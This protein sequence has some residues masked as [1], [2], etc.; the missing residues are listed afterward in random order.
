MGPVVNGVKL[1]LIDSAYTE[2]VTILF[3]CYSQCKSCVTSER[4]F[5]CVCHQHRRY[6]SAAAVGAC[7][8]HVFVVTPS[9]PSGFPLPTSAFHNN[10]LSYQA[11]SHKKGS[12]ASETYVQIT[13]NLD[14]YGSWVWIGK[15]D[16]R[17]SDPKTPRCSHSFFSFLYLGP[18]ETWHAWS[19]CYRKSRALP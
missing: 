15:A 10:Y 2:R 19:T 16:W 8:K 14:S 11:R 12:G 17:L 3:F 1:N 6:T 13:D 18:R 7:T 4:K 5:R 9:A